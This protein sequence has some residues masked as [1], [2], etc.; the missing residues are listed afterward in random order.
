MF[1]CID[2]DNN[3]GHLDLVP[4]LEKS[5]YGL[6]V[7]RTSRIGFPR[8]ATRIVEQDFQDFSNRIEFKV[9]QKRFHSLKLVC[10]VLFVAVV[11]LPQSR[12]AG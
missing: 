11:R 7:K 4:S 6:R 1:M 12:L 8:D 9:S 3:I 5:R 10:D 2:E